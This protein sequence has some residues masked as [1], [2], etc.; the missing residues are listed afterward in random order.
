MID[1]HSDWGFRI[2]G[3][4]CVKYNNTYIQKGLCGRKKKPRWGKRT[5]HQYIQ[6]KAR[7]GGEILGSYDFFA[8]YPSKIVRSPAAVGFLTPLLLVPFF[9]G[10]DDIPRGSRARSSAAVDYLAPLLL[11]PLVPGGWQRHPLLPVSP[12]ASWASSHSLRG[13]EMSSIT[14]TPS[15]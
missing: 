13:M 3:I 2:S 5:S 11:V 9:P 14:V 4:T 7:I 6:K 1:S 12:P 10:G 8:T 15:E